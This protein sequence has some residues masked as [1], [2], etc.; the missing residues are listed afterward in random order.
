MTVRVFFAATV[1]F[2][3]PTIFLPSSISATTLPAGS[4]DLKE[5]WSVLVDLTAV[6]VYEL[7]L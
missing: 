5:T 3:V 7:T 4:V 6:S 2:V 1:T